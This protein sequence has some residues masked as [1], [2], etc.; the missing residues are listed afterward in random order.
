MSARRSDELRTPRARRDPSP[1]T[2][3]NGK[4]AVNHLV[5]PLVVACVG[6]VGRAERFNGHHFVD[7]EESAALPQPAVDS[8]SQ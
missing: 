2:G 8:G 5:L 7:S 4:L 1:A 6:L 3:A